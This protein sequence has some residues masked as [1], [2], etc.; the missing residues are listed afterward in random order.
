MMFWGDVQAP[1]G[2]SAGQAAFAQVG[3]YCFLEWQSP[4]LT[5]FLLVWSVGFYTFSCR[6]FFA[7]LSY[8]YHHSNFISMFLSRLFL[9]HH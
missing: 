7:C 6:D 8:C 1:E 2:V 5:Q 4:S 9:A 3:M